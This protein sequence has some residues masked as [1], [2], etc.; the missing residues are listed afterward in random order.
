M[1]KS[2]HNQNPQL[3]FII[4]QNFVTDRLQASKLWAYFIAYFILTITIATQ[5]NVK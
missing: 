1:P 5:K 4:I 3:K 2:K